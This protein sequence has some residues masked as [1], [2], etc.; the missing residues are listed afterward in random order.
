MTLPSIWSSASSASCSS[1]TAAAFREMRR[2]LQQHGTVLFNTWATIDTHGFAAALL[3]G[4]EPAFPTTRPRSWSLSRTATPTWIRSPPTWPL[5]ASSECQ[6][7]P[8]R[9]RDAP[10][11]PQT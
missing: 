5:A 2:V 4:V 6:Q 3:V 8:L 10:A 7:R 11:R 1:P 9:S